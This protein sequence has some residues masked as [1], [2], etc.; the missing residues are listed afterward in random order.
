MF[1][2]KYDL[3]KLEEGVNHRHLSTIDCLMAR[4]ACLFVSLVLL[5]AAAKKR[6]KEGFQDCASSGHITKLKQYILET[7]YIYGVNTLAYCAIVLGR[8]KFL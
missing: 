6:R 7:F 8:K 4:T 3:E 5:M 1:V 2:G